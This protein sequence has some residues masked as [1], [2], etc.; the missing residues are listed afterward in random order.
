MRT[1]YSRTLPYIGRCLFSLRLET[2]TGRVTFLNSHGPF[3]K[4]SPFEEIE[5]CEDRQGCWTRALQYREADCSIHHRALDERALCQSRLVPA[6]R[7]APFEARSARQTTRSLISARRRLQF[8]TAMVTT[9]GNPSF[10]HPHKDSRYRRV[11]LDGADHAFEAIDQPCLACLVMPHVCRSCHFIVT[12]CN[13]LPVSAG[14][15]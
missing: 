5:H 4:S 7:R 15:V 14:S 11:G 9:F 12:I 13:I 8:W 6:I 3:I 10:P 2:T 1:L